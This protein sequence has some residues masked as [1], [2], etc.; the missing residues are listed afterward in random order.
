MCFD[1]VGNLLTGELPRDTP[2]ILHTVVRML[3]STSS[4]LEGSTG[5]SMALAVR[6]VLFQP[7]HNLSADLDAVL[8]TTLFPYQHRTLALMGVAEIA[9]GVL[10]PQYAGLRKNYEV[11]V[12]ALASQSKA[13]CNCLLHR[14]VDDSARKSDSDWGYDPAFD[15]TELERRVPEI[16]QMLEPATAAVF[17]QSWLGSPPQSSQ[18]IECKPS[19]ATADMIRLMI[20]SAESRRP[21]RYRRPQRLPLVSKDFLQERKLMLQ[22][23]SSSVHESGRCF[24]VNKQAAESEPE[25]KKVRCMTSLVDVRYSCPASFQLAELITTFSRRQFGTFAAFAPS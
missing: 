9:I 13:L 7:S 6:A 12:H 16:L 2:Y 20:L 25:W 10:R 21:F 15:C 23:L 19:D 11:I 22:K 17:E 8:Q 24:D 14:E 18:K 1:H 5:S 4:F 3:E